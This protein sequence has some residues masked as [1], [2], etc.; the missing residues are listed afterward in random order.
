M[1]LVNKTFDGKDMPLMVL[2]GNKTDLSH[3]RAVKAE[4]HEKFA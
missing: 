2:M 3:M 1:A 4:Q